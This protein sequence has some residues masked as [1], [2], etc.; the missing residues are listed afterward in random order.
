MF[1]PANGVLSAVRMDA[2]C[3]ERVRSGHTTCVRLETHR[4]CEAH[5]NKPADP[6]ISI[7]DMAQRSGVAAS[8]LRYYEKLGLICSERE[9]SG[10]HRRYRESIFHKIQYVTLAQRAGFSLEEIAEQLA[11]LP[12]R[13]PPP[14]KQWEPLSKVWLKRIDERIA[15]LERLKVDIANC[16]DV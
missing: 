8:T 7:R 14:R 9:G 13:L 6:L 12:E 2:E 16:R 1:R 11:A 15:G 4:K 10:E 5:M 3:G